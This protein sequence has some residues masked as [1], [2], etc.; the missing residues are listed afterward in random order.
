MEHSSSVQGIYTILSIQGEVDLHFSPE[1]RTLILDNLKANK[2][3]LVDL[4]G[5]TYIDSSGIACFVEGFQYSRKHSLKFGLL[6]VAD[7]VMSV[8]QLARLDKVFPIYD[9]VENA[10]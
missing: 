9:S 6:R 8:L 3:V 1:L 10:S 5:V 2:P 7:A 4:S